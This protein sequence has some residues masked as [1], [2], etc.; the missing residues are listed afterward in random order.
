[1]KEKDDKVTYDFFEVS[2]ANLQIIPINY[3]LMK[4]L[5][6]GERLKVR[7]ADSE[8]HQTKTYKLNEF[9]KPVSPCV[10]FNE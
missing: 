2:N 7:I 3:R 1:M 5:T 6:S 9:Y 10:N 8:F 4:K